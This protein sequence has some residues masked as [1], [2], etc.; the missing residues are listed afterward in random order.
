MYYINLYVETSFGIWRKEKI[1]HRFLPAHSYMKPTARS[2]VVHHPPNRS[3]ARAHTHI[4]MRELF[5]YCTPK[6]TFCDPTSR[7]EMPILS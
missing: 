6:L 3:R 1:E 2:L 4:Y 5:S 7:V